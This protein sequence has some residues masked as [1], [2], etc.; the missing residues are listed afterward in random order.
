[1]ATPAPAARIVILGAGRAQRGGVPTAML[2][3]GQRGRV[4]DW[5]LGAFSVIPGASICVVGGF[6]A[7]TLHHEVPDIELV[8][9]PNWRVTGPAISLSYA[10]LPEGAPLWVSYADVVFRDGTVRAIEQIDADI[11]LAIDRA[12]TRRYDRRGARELARAEKVTCS[13]DRVTDIGS[14]IQ[15]RAAAGEFCGLVKF[16]PRVVTAI[17]EIFARSELP[18][19]ASM[20]ALIRALL[21]RGFQARVTDVAG[22]WA[23]L[24]APQDLAQFVL[25]TKAES[26][27]RLK[28]RLRRGTIG[29]LLSF[30]HARWSSERGPLVERVRA[31]FPQTRLIVRSSAQSEDGWTE[32]AAGAYTSV[33]DVD[34]GDPAAVAAAI[35]EVFASYGAADPDNHVLVQ[36][37]LRDVKVSG[38]VMT[39]TPTA[40]APY[41]VLN[42]DSTTRRTDTVTSGEGRALRTVY[43][44]RDAPLTPRLEPELGD[45]VEVVKELEAL[46]GHD[47]L[48][49]E[50]AITD[51]GLVHVLQVRPI[52]VQ[53]ELPV[54]D[55]ALERTLRRAMKL[56]ERMQRTRSPFIVGE[57]TQLSVMSDWNPA[58]IVGVK[59]RRLAFSLYRHLITD[60]VWAAQR[61]RNGYR[62]V[63][64]CNLLVDIAGHP[65]VDVRAT[66]N[67]F[68][69]ATLPDAL[70]G[71]LVDHYL[72]VLRD[73]P[74]LH[75]KIE[76]DVVFTC[77]TL[78]FDRRATRLR[79]AGFSGDDIA[80]LRA[81][82]QEVTRRSVSSVDRD[83]A[84]VEQ[85]KARQRAILSR[86]LPPLERAFLLL[87]DVRRHG[88][89]VF[90]NLARSGF[91][92]V[93][94]LRSLTAAGL[95][96]EA[97][98]EGFL[99]SL[100]TVS[101]ALQ[102]D[103]AAVA[104]GEM[105]WEALLEV[106]GHLRPGTYDIT[107]PSYSAA[108]DEFLRPMVALAG[109]AASDEDGDARWDEAARA[110]AAAET[111]AALELELSWD[112]LA[113]FLRASIEGREFSKFVFTRSV[114]VALE[115]LA[116]FGARYGLSR[117]DLAH[118]EI[119]ELLRLREA[120]SVERGLGDLLQA[121]AHEGRD[122][123]ARAQATCLPGHITTVADFLC[124]EQAPARA[125][126]IT[127]KSVQA[128]LVDLDHATPGG[129]ALAGTIVLISHADPGYDWLFGREIAGL[130]TRYGGANSH[131]AIRAAEFGLP[132][133][134]GVGEA[135][136]DQL[137]RAQIVVLDCEGHSIRVVGGA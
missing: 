74:E 32:S 73:A 42:F 31:K 77:M 10:R 92:A 87:E 24:N 116:E 6:R 97:Q 108:A 64:P 94:L 29:E 83:L 39:R 132:A 36:E 51:D 44:H 112:E 136:Y 95:A 122:A 120:P 113:R 107:S 8:I 5:I 2:P 17:R 59:P 7:D 38:V 85:L 18:A 34:S 48:D 43:L 30:T 93:S 20:P 99:R 66:F 52:A 115:A 14:H 100:R 78:D 69:P 89:L 16:R 55:H 127:R 33:I 72:D 109:D 1:M 88:T 45:V 47:S 110:R 114:S 124:F 84:A 98:V 106:Y 86:D 126:F 46:V 134:I 104:R 65:Y 119:R 50:F 57:S 26:L 75:D 105:T 21:G 63:R 96:S 71:R 9:N 41:Y 40:G 58:E 111:G 121:R 129:V 67:S 131:M 82:L 68:V 61:A 28:P 4:I 12:W 128:P 37:L 102:R 103:A 49:I 15:S 123:F 118:L 25:G 90:A 137:R 117:E 91:V 70:A 130:I 62:D 19:T 125:N 27:E 23:E 35:D 13:R 56:F 11:V 80:L 53:H 54:D 3:T 133:A 22:D 81:G 79:D 135:T 76:F 60:A 101:G